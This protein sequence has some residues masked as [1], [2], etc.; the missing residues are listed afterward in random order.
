MIKD[1]AKKRD[2]FM[3]ARDSTHQK[4]DKSEKPEG[5]S[6]KP[7][8]NKSHHQGLQE[9]LSPETF[10]QIWR[11]KGKLKG[12]WCPY[13]VQGI[14]GPKDCWYLN[15][16]K[17]PAMWR[18]STSIWKYTSPTANLAAN[19][20]KD[21]EMAKP[22]ASFIG[23]AVDTSLSSQDWIVDSGC[24]KSVSGSLNDFNDYHPWSPND[25]PYQYGSVAGVSGHTEGWGTVKLEL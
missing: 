1:L 6:E 15:P 17:R 22:T 12:G 16:K 19:N 3:F 7:Q 5:K 23:A 4:N 13:C 10:R 25:K 11:S 20:S 21:D 8:V 18:G 2:N 24:S 9:G 14:H